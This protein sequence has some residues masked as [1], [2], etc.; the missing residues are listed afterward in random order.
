MAK[1]K[2]ILKSW[3][4]LLLLF[5]IALALVAINPKFSQDGVA[6][7]NVKMNS[8][9]SIAG[10]KNPLPTSLPTSRE[11][12]TELNSVKIS[13]EEDYYSLLATIKP[14]ATVYV[15]TNKDTYILKA[16]EAFETKILN[17][18]V[19][20]NITE[21]IYNETSKQNVTVNKT[22]LVNKTESISRGLED[23]GLSVYPAPKS[24]IRLGLDLQGGTRVILQPE[25]KLSLENM[26]IVLDNMKQRLNIYG[27]SDISVKDSS[28][29]IS[30]EQY[31]VIE[32]AGAS[33]EEV[34]NLL[35][36][37]GKFEAKI[38]SETVFLG[39][40]DITYVCRSSDCA[41]IDPSYG[42]SQ[43]GNQF[44]CRFRFSISL[45]PLAA[46]RQA[47]LTN[48]LEV[49]GDYLSKDLTLILD[50]EE[51]D[52]LKI[53]A[54]L[55]GRAV[56]DI[57]ISGSGAGA[58]QQEAISN[59]LKEMKRLQSVLVTGSL[60]VKLNIVESD[61]ISPALG[62]EF[63]KNSFL[64]GFLAIMVVSIIVYV[65]YRRINVAVPVLIGM[66]SEVILLF[67]FA[68]L[69]GWNI[70]IAAIAGIIVAIGTS[71]DN[72]V[73]FA[74]ETL[75][76]SSKEQNTLLDWREKVKRAISI[77]LTSYATS[78]VAMLPL[79]FV[80]AGLVKG[81]AITTIAGLTLGVFVSRPAFA[82]VVEI[83]LND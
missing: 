59:S 29:P 47:A 64:I 73:V 15:K 82:K 60:P 68:S 62:K 46:E 63:I 71:V 14:N 11:V 78:V 67:G 7:R 58:N 44:I 20:V 4:V 70:D 42:C 52:S 6:I 27:L 79:L 24:N 33:K 77:I 53:G 39:G 75:S 23:I 76:S 81:F 74:D 55:R 61:S 22:I 72:L 18:L 43:S 9:A 34:K 49:I 48:N 38:G 83:L 30:G 28:D 41:G 35:A 31:I 37:Q 19:E 51:V 17:E 16:R 3:R 25:K 32:I 66:L 50:D 13:N 54:D 45:T 5:F 56:T 80:G 26:S 36:Q 69:V 40:R 2:Q 65:R 57:Q 12:V 8:S 10:I 21:E 1:I